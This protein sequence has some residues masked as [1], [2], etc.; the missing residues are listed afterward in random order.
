MIGGL[1][2]ISEIVRSKANIDNGGRTRF[3]DMWHGI[4]LLACVALIPTV[5]HR[6]PLAALAAMLIYTGFRLTHPREFMHVYSI[7][8]E[9]LLVFVATLVGV[10]ATDLLIGI[11]IGIA[12]EL[13]IH[14]VHG[15]S[16]RSLFRPCLHVDLD[17]EEDVVVRAPHSAVFSNWIPFRR[18]IVENGLSSRRNVTVDLSQTKLVD[19]SVMEKLHDL[20]Q[21]FDSAGVRLSFTG[22]DDLVPLSKHKHSSRKRTRKKVKV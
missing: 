6:I 20:Q 19:H 9:Q 15:A 5:L 16:V 8:K 21:E 11:L 1:P 18:K 3:A 14:V 12:V 7:G 10:L 17:N 2:M 22:L 4:F 13:V